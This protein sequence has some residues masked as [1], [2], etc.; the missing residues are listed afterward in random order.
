MKTALFW[1]AALFRQNP[2]KYQHTSI[3]LHTVTPL[4]TATFYSHEESLWDEKENNT[5]GIV[6]ASRMMQW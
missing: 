5:A 4:T 3:T 1:N 2:L 6:L